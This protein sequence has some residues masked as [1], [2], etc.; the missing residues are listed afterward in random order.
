MVLNRALTCFAV[1]TFGLAWAQTALAVSLTSLAADASPSQNG[2]VVRVGTN[3][4]VAGTSDVGTEGDTAG[5]FVFQLPTLALGESVTNANFSVRAVEGSLT[6]TP[7]FNIDLYGLGFRTTSAVA[8]G[9]YFE[10]ALDATDATLIAD[11]FIVPADNANGNTET[12]AAEDVSLANYINAQYTAGAGGQ[13]IFLRV[14]ADATVPNGE[15]YFFG[16]NEN[17]TQKPVL[18]FDVV[19][20]PSVVA[21]LSVAAPA[22]LARRRRVA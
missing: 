11:N 18:T 7:T 21:L 2:N 10:A 22:L 15:R 3:S 20:E 1:A 9:D 13:F 16:S 6:N 5:V 17:T 12:T 19:P 8:A 4:L 14:N